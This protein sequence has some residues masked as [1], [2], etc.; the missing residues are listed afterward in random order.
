MSFLPK[1]DVIEYLMLLVSE[2]DFDLEVRQTELFEPEVPHNT[3]VIR[4]SSRPIEGIGLPP[5][6]YDR[7]KKMFIVLK[8]MHESL[9]E[10][11][12][13]VLRIDNINLKQ[14]VKFLEEE[15]K[16]YRKWTEEGYDQGWHDSRTFAF[17]QA[18]K[19]CEEECDYTHEICRAHQFLSDYCRYECPRGEKTMGYSPVTCSSA[20][21]D[22]GEVHIMFNGFVSHLNS[23][24]S[25]RMKPE[26][27]NIIRRMR[28][29]CLSDISDEIKDKDLEGSDE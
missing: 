21:C 19:I 18:G 11:K 5:K 15:V 24:T 4:G 8:A 2:L 16:M 28:D 26:G 23:P 13:N 7:L 1:K 9:Y 6:V 17:V 25:Y 14:K 12:L 29:G 27:Y 10:T 20:S 3:R 22:V